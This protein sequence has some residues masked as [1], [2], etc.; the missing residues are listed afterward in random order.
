MEKVIKPVRVKKMIDF[1]SHV[2]PEIDDGAGS[3]EESVQMLLSLKEQGITTVVA[4]PHY[5]GQ[6]SVD[7]FLN[8]R[9]QSY[10][11]LC[12]F[13]EEIGAVLPKVVLGAEVALETYALIG[14]SIK[15]L[16]IEGM[17][18]IL[19]EMPFL[20][21]NGYL[22]DAL[23]DISQKYGLQVIIA[24][25]DRYF[26]LFGDKRR[27]NDI[28]SMV[29]K[30]YALQLNTS[31]LSSWQGKRLLRKLVSLG[32]RVVFGSDCHNMEDRKPV[33]GKYK[34]VISRYLSALDKGRVFENI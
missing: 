13:A 20:L 32:G 16:C 22:F 4:T 19:I 31:A 33:Y 27:N 9:R 6:C 7:E 12:A 3:V 18:C 34:K 28:F 15:D 1:H 10:D 25:I 24:H 23:D 21:W 26:S 2:L 5:K 17:D 11:C 14:D 8:R 29:D 30:N